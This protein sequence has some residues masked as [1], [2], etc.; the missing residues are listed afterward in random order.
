MCR[1]AGIATT[2]ANILGFPQDTRDSVLEHLAALR[3]ISPEMASFYILTPIPGT[4]QYD[5][6]RRQGLITEPNLD[7]FDASTLTWRHPNLSGSD[8]QELVFHC[9]REFFSTYDSLRKGWGA[10]RRAH[11]VARSPGFC[12]LNV[13][14]GFEV[15]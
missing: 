2:F 8:L 5:D 14:G 11:R 1:E 10:F 3:E 6:F 13:A 15:H 9:Y 12:A 7:R 4:D